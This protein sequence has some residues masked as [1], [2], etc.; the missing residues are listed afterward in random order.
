MNIT[1][2]FF[3]GI[4][5]CTLL[6]TATA[7]IQAQ[8]I[9]QKK[10]SFS[11]QQQRLDDVLNIISNKGNFSFSYNSSILKRDSLISYTA[12]DYT[13]DRILNELLN[14]SFEY[15]ESGGYIIIRKTALRVTSII[16]QSPGG[17]HVFTITGYVVNSETGEPI[18]NASIYEPRHLASTLTNKEGR[19]QIRLRNH[20]QPASLAISRDRFQD[21]TVLINPGYNAQLEIAIVPAIEKPLLSTVSMYHRVTPVVQKDSL[22]VPAIQPARIEHN[23]LAKLLL[24]A[25]LKTQS[26]NIPELLGNRS[27]QVSLVPGFGTN[28]NMG[29][30]IENSFSLNIIGGYTGGVNGAELGGVFNINKKNV[31]YAQLAGAANLVG[32][33]MKGVQIAGLHNTVLQYMNGIQLSGV[34]NHVNQAAKGIQIAGIGNLVKD[35]LHGIQL[36]GINNHVQR[37][38]RGIQIAG[39]GNI[40]AGDADGVQIAGIFNY[41]KRLKGVQIGLVNVADTVDGYS[42]G[43]VNIVKKGY[44][45]LYISN[46]EVTHFNLAYKTGN[47][48]LYSILRGGLNASAKEKLYSMGYGIGT[49]IRL[50][51]R[52]YCNPELSTDFLYAGSWEYNNTL[53]RLQLLFDLRL[54]PRLSLTAGPS[55]ALLYSNQARAE[56]GYAFP[57]AGAHTFQWFSNKQLITWF[58]WNAGLTLF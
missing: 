13:V 17:E 32:G 53:N 46:N 15:K 31:R 19:F 34:S 50:A 25:R 4:V 20:H 44:H 54:S 48:N 43:L 51:N 57:A 16:Q 42:I 2:N 27:I 9:L 30:Q 56:H 37:N 33:E 39:V 10:L 40:T 3:T 26:L 14:G 45:K 47:A 6:T 36:A 49:S 12:S 55:F 38:S 41:A 22:F 7:T 8:G 29:S 21:T 52:I 5:L 35:T 11:V 23:R 1:R 28:G 24:S 58:G 18:G